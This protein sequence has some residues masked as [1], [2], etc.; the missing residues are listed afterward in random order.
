MA[1][2]EI[3]FDLSYE[4]QIYTK[5]LKMKT[6]AQTSVAKLRDVAGICQGVFVE[7]RTQEVA[8]RTMQ[9]IAEKYGQLDTVIGVA[10]LYVLE[11][12]KSV[13]DQDKVIAANII[14]NI[15]ND[16]ETKEDEKK[17]IR[18]NKEKLLNRIKE[19]VKR[20][21]EAEEKGE[22]PP[23]EPQEN[24]TP[25]A[26]VTPVS[27]S[28]NSVPNHTNSGNESEPSK[29]NAK[30]TPETKQEKKVHAGTFSFGKL[31]ESTQ[32]D[33]F[34]VNEEGFAMNGETPILDENGNPVHYDQIN[35]IVNNV[36]QTEG[37]ASTLAA[38]HK[39]VESEV[40]NMLRDAKGLKQE[41]V[42][43]TLS[44]FKP[45]NALAGETA[46]TTVEPYKGDNTVIKGSVVFQPKS[47]SVLQASHALH[48][49]PEKKEELRKGF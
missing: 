23:A 15:L 11:T 28:D 47:T 30:T 2:E 14:N 35:D 3:K 26:P 17:Q 1:N 33:D 12:F 44:H 40:Y 20:R 34:W 18:E 45:Q 29:V 25:S 42:L 24:S 43:H 38:A 6:N 37:F 13:I 31:S 19:S 41:T 36:E 9:E 22:E 4:E 27:A 5:L 7:G 21:R 16:P 49:N 48:I 46:I 39:P 10:Q 32:T 8:I